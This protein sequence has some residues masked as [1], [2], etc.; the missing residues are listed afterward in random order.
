MEHQPC[1]GP[2]CALSTLVGMAGRGCGSRGPRALTLPGLAL[3]YQEGPAAVAWPEQQLLCLL[4]ADTLIQPPAQVWGT[5]RAAPG[6]AGTCSAPR[7]VLSWP[8]QRGQVEV[9]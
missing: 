9:Q 7:P 8:G 3:P 6:C 2:A 5:G 1:W 4:P